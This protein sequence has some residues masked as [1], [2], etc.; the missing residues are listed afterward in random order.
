M[1]TQTSVS[2]S[3][4]V[5]VKRKRLNICPLCLLWSLLQT[6]HIWTYVCFYTSIGTPLFD[7]KIVL[8]I[9]LVLSWNHCPQNYK[10]TLPQRIVIWIW[11]ISKI[12]YNMWYMYLPHHSDPLRLLMDSSLAKWT[13][14]VENT[15]SL[16]EGTNQVLFY[17]KEVQKDDV[18]VYAG[19]KE[20]S[21]AVLDTYWEQFFLFFLLMVLK[22]P[23]WIFF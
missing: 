14:W 3:L 11:S 1:Q 5:L 12:S 6:I 19:R 13:N 16:V 9:E 18:F 21:H 10:C 20:F 2:I 4:L 22:R 15:T 8:T 7:K 23:S 17:L